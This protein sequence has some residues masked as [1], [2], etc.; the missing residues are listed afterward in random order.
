MLVYQRVPIKIGDLWWSRS[1]IP[2]PSAKGAAPVGSGEV[3]REA[4]AFE[5]HHVGD[6]NDFAHLHGNPQMPWKIAPW[7]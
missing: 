7:I 5:A 1:T 2:R 6:A 3:P 4:T